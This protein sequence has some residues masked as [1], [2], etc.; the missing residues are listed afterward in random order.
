MLQGR[1]RFQCLIKAQAWQEIRDSYSGALQAFGPLQ[2]GMRIS[3]DL[4]PVSML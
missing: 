3:L 1:V 4:D 2:E